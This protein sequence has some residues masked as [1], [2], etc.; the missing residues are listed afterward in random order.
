M[1]GKEK[2][3]SKCKTFIA[4]EGATKFCPNCGTAVAKSTNLM[5]C[6]CLMLIGSVFFIGY[7]ASKVTS[8]STTTQTTRTESTAAVREPTTV[9][10]EPPTSPTTARKTDEPSISSLWRY[11]ADED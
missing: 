11:S 10:R 6:G 8:K 9:Q 4:G 7:F 5:G 3:C 2:W 1:A